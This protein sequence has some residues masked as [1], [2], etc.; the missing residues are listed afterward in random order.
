MRHAT[1]GYIRAID[2]TLLN[3]LADWLKQSPFEPFL[4]HLPE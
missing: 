4:S 3:D 2:L 1:D